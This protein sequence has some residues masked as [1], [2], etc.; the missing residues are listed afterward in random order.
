MHNATPVQ[1]RIVP[2]W[3]PIRQ[4]FST[5][6]V[7][8]PGKLV[9]SSGNDR[10]FPVELVRRMERFRLTPDLISA[11]ELLES[12]I[13]FEKGAEAVGAARTLI[14]KNS[15][16]VPLLKRQAARLLAREGAIE[17]VPRDLI[18]LIEV[19]LGK[20]R[21]RI[22]TN[23]GD[24]LAWTELARTQF[25]S[26]FADSAKKSI[27]IALALSPQS[28]HT[29][30]A[31]VRLYYQTHDFDIAYSLVRDNPATPTDPWLMAAEVAVA[32]FAGKSP[33]FAKR[34][35][36]LVDAD[37]ELPNQV[38]ELAV[39]LGTLVLKNGSS[40]R[41]R[42]LVRKGLLAPTINAVA[43]AEWL[44]SRSGEDL[45]DDKDIAKAQGAWE[46]RTI[47]A[48]KNGIF[49]D[50][51]AF[52]KKWVLSEEYNPEAYACTASVANTIDR[53]DDTLALCREAFRISAPSEGVLNAFVFANASLGHLDRAEETLDRL[54][55]AQGL[56]HAI[57]LANR[58]FIAFKRGK[59]EPAKE[60]YR[61]AIA[62]FQKLR[63]Q[64]LEASCLL[65]YALELTK[66]NMQDESA[67]V[68]KRFKD[69]TRV[70]KV[71]NIQM[72][73]KLMLAKI[74]TVLATPLAPH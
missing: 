22:K 4:T 39:A 42:N 5:G 67:L 73:E 56:H 1:R 47:H 27:R 16:A 45:V 14:S 8:A 53:F 40:R 51:L 72:L 25:C 2:Q 46:A 34:G 58:G 19:A 21:S 32:E 43:Q 28:R 10:G 30:R 41:G 69:L 66:A 71:P 36:Q 33:A 23:P 37:S 68:I 24:V 57:A 20:P 74:D 63:N 35:L 52:G 9:E 31:A 60:H 62:A 26:G 13:I 38:S 18:P 65:Y 15:D 11:A 70:L 50:S 61:E 59:F 12:S 29:V 7:A 6:E 17:D 64:E 48:F 3:R 49:E 55:S 54:K 44:S